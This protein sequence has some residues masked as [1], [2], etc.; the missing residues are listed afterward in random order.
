MSVIVRARDDASFRRRYG[1]WA[2]ITGAA[3]G[4]G[5]AFAEALARRGLSLLLVDQQAQALQ[6]CAARVAA[7]G[8]GAVQPIAVD[9][10]REDFYAALAPHVAPREIGLWK[11]YHRARKYL[12]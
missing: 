3:Q 9:L 7:L 1:P 4:L 11:A 5:R 6:D 8:P 2:L 12:R 10:A